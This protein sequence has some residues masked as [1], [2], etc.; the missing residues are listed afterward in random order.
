MPVPARRPV[1][2]ASL[3]FIYSFVLISPMIQEGTA[4]E[5]K[6]CWIR[7]NNDRKTGLMSI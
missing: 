7:F 1:F 5:Q 4:K 2:F 3:A 6:D